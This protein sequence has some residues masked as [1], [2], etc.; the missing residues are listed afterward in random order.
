M[1]LDRQTMYKPFYEL[2]IGGKRVDESYKKYITQVE[3]EDSDTEAG[4]ARIYVVDKGFSF[5]NNFLLDKETPLKLVMGFETY[6]R[7]ML[8]GKVSHFE[9]DFDDSGT[10]HL[11]IGAIDMSGEMDKNKRSRV[12]ENATRSEV[13]ASIASEYGYKAS[14]Q[15]TTEVLEQ[16]SQDNVT[17]AQL[18]KSLADEEAYELFI[19]SD[20]KELFYGNQFQDIQAKDTLYYDSGDF[21]IRSFTPSYVEKNKNIPTD[22]KSSDLSQKSGEDYTNTAGV[23]VDVTIQDD[24]L[25]EDV[26]VS[27]LTGDSSR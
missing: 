25:G 3:F 1:V 6:N 21:S 16:V 20:R 22:D 4:L 15:D 17:D 18:L 12:W 8:D 27:G 2:T 10:R 9:A 26:L 11:V 5:S 19:F 23:N 14:I 7:V 24:D 13:V